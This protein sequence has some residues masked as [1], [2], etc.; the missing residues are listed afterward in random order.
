MS[1]KDIADLYAVF[2]LWKL[3]INLFSMQK[4]AEN[5]NIVFYKQADPVVPNSNFVCRIVAF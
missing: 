4:P 1:F 2:Y 3:F 5:Y